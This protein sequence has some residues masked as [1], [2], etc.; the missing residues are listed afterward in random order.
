MSTEAIYKILAIIKEECSRS[1]ATTFIVGVIVL[2]VCAAVANG[3]LSA[4]NIAFELGQMSG[5]FLYDL[6]H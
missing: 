3:L 6:L 1:K 2:G 4:G 5:G